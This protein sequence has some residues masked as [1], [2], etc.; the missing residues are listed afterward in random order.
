MTTRL[1]KLN[2]PAA[3][4]KLSRKGETI[5]VWDE[6]RKKNLVLSPEEWVRQHVVYYLI[7]LGYP[8]SNMALE[9]GLYLNKQLRRTDILV[10]KGGKPAMLVEC[11]APGVR[12]GQDTFDQ[13]SRYN[14][15]LKV[16]YIMVSNGLEHYI[17][18][19]RNQE[20]FDFLT[21]IPSYDD[22]DA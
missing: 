17:A 8:S 5:F 7:S 11:K 9:S 19:V 20:G 22:I 13:A 15:E 1:P 6:L 2:L 4:L 14:L 10:Y 12:L 21:E 3:P 18:L 16:R